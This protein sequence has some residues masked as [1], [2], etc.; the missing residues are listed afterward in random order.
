MRFR[1][2]LVVFVCLWPA[3]G[4]LAG[5]VH[6]CTGPDGEPMFSQSPCGSA[7]TASV[8]RVAP[9]GTAGSGLR[10][11]ELEWLADRDRQR[12]KSG[13]RDARAK[14]VPADGKVAPNECEKRKVSLD[15]VNARLRRGY[16]PAQGERLRHRRRMLENYIAAACRR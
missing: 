7:A 5:H 4:A 3:S 16:T 12:A 14:P 8:I 10:G 9:S 13:M 15:D 11:T 1:S 2:H 6:R